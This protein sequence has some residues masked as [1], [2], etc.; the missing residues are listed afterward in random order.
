M[1]SYNWIFDFFFYSDPLEIV[2]GHS[3]Y[4]GEIVK[5]RFRMPTNDELQYGGKEA[6]YP[7]K[8]IEGQ[9]EKLKI[10]WI[11]CNFYYCTF[12]K[13]FRDHVN[14]TEYDIKYGHSWIRNVWSK[15]IFTHRKLYH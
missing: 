6:Y 4:L 8:R 12:K 15:D 11:V 1:K 2:P 7:Q 10:L 5:H 14:D 13:H 3:R 9:W